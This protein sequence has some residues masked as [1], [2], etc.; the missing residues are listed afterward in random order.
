MSKSIV[1]KVEKVKP[2]KISLI[3]YDSTKFEEKNIDQIEDFFHLKKI[4]GVT[5]LN[6]DGLK[7]IELIDKIG[8]C[9][10]IHPLVLEDIKT[11]NQRPKVEVFDDYIF[12]VIKMLAF[13]EKKFRITSEQVSI[14]L[15]KNFVISFQEKVGDL[16]DPLREKIRK[17]KGKIRKMNSDYLTYSLLDMIIDYYFNILEKIGDK[18]EVFEEELMSEPKPDTLNEIYKLKREVLNLRKSV[19]PLREAIN[20]IEKTDSPII[21]KKT[22]PYIRDLYVHTIQIIDTVE[23]SRDLLSGMLE[24]YLSSVSNKMN[25][26]MKVLTIFAAIFIPLTFITGIYGTNFDFIPELKWKYGYFG[27]LLFMLLVGLG[28]LLFFKRKKWI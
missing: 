1:A 2:S 23:T 26:I 28:L 16:F 15:G 6:I 12:I 18:I 13:N 20:K 21:R 24:L 4:P 19:W 10:E 5:W 14:I 17:G 3:N 8:N 27:M 22:I 9:Y 7:D 25:E 11:I